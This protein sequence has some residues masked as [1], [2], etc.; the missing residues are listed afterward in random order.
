MAV[1]FLLPGPVAAI[2]K[3]VAVFNAEQETRITEVVREY[4]VAHPEVIGEV[5]QRLL[6]QREEKQQQ[7]RVAAVI[8]NQAALLNDKGTPSYGS[9]D[10]KVTVVEFF[11]YQCIYCA[12]LAPELEKAI[13]ANP[14]VRLVFKELPIFGQY[15]PTSMRAAKTG[16]QIWQQKG[17]EAYFRYH[18]M[19]YATGH[20]EGKLT[21]EDINRAADAVKFNISKAEGVQSVLDGINTQA[22]QLGISGTPTLVILPSSGASTG[23]VTVIPGAPRTDALQKAIDKAAGKTRL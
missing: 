22:Q 14:N 2:E 6:A 21:D 1:G 5:E 16:L 4:L 9:G 11:D 18:N 20:N 12:R 19:I 7:A 15:W 23:N 10:A 3:P 17:A 13:K 8:Q